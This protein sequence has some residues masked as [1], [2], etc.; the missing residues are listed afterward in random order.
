MIRT[1]E[2]IVQMKGHCDV[3]DLT[4]ALR[5]ALATSG[6]VGGQALTFVVGSTAGVTTV[7][8]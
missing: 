6:L 3:H 7:E 5:R 8:F 2:H 4:P 1:T